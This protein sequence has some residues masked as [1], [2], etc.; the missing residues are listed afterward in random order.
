MQKLRDL[1]ATASAVGIA[2]MLG[3]ATGSG[4]PQ[5]SFK[6]LNAC[7]RVPGTAVAAAL[8]GRPVDERPVNSKGLTAARCV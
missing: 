2:V 6:S 7:Q 8:S 5:T 1:V 3:R 4:A